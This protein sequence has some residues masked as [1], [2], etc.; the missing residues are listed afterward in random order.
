M[1]GL[2]ISRITISIA[3]GTALVMGALMDGPTKPLANQAF[4]A[5]PCSLTVGNEGTTTISGKL[6]CG[7]QGL[8]HATIHLTLHHI[9]TGRTTTATA[10]TEIPDGSYDHAVV[11]GAGH[12]YTADAKYDGDSDHQ[13]A[14]AT[15][16][17]NIPGPTGSTQ[18]TSNAGNGQQNNNTQASVTVPCSLTVGTPPDEVV[19]AS[20]EGKLICGGL[21]EPRATIQISGLP[22]GSDSTTTTNGGSYELGVF[23]PFSP[24]QS[25]TVTAKYDGDSN[26]HLQPTSATTIINIKGSTGS[27][28]QNNNA[29]STPQNNNAGSTPQNNNAG[30][31]QDT[32]NAGNG[33]DTSNAGN[34][35]D[36]SNA[37][38][39]QDTSNAGNSAG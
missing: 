9:T 31:G 38:N 13:P 16:S 35:Q 7:G 30:N 10:V 28:P 5:T 12:S 14:F 22:G 33:Q 18:G 26:Q 3:M 19:P 37:G 39:G 27:T 36:T 34:G 11:L 2:T 1:K 6:V 24:G 21:G 25:Y 8:G 17:I 29:G 15:T 20:I 4:A 23:S 32:S